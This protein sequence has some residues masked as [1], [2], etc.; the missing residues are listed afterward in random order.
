MSALAAQKQTTQAVLDAYNSWDL[1][2]ILAFRAPNCEQ[3][4]LPASMGR[5]SM[6]NSEY[7][8]RMKEL[9]PLFRKFTVTLTSFAH[10]TY[11]QLTSS[12]V[13][14]HTAVHDADEHK[15]IMHATSTAE[16]D[17]G[18]YGNEYALVLFFTDDGKKVTKFLEYVDSA[19]A[20]QFFARLAEAGY[21]I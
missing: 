12:Q 4:V 1:E 9:L 14:V 19:Y 6:N 2:K 17:I 13:T 15:C 7:R 10:D 5:P 3:Q 21:G 8:T 18:P 16:T 11:E 20:M